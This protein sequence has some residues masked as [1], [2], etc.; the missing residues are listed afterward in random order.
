MLAAPASAPRAL[1]VDTSSAANLTAPTQAQ[2]NNVYAD[3][4]RFASLRS[5]RGGL[6][7]GEGL[8]DDAHFYD[9]ISRATTANLL[10]GPYHFLRIDLAHSG[11]NEAQHMFIYAGMYMKPGYLLPVGDLEGSNTRTP[12]QMT[13]FALEFVTTIESQMGITPMMYMQGSFANDDEITKSLAFTGSTP[14]TY[15]WVAR[16]SGDINT[17]NPVPAQHFP[18]M[19]GMYDPA[20]TTRTPN[21][22]AVG[23]WPT[24]PLLMSRQ[25]SERMFR[26]R[27]TIG[28]RVVALRG[29]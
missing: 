29:H 28:E 23:S 5:S 19:Y 13:T 11:V 26:H 25:S 14:R 17:G 6:T 24:T 7:A 9:N 2:W 12:S 15:L 4:Y 20:F 21:R 8:Q 18:N 22:S 10:S 16:Y 1:G 27:P 3:G